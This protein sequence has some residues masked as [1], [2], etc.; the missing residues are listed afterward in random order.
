MEMNKIKL[1]TKI[2]ISFSVV[3]FVIFI[4][5]SLYISLYFMKIQEH[6]IIENIDDMTSKFTKQIDYYMR[7]LTQSARNLAYEPKLIEQ[8]NLINQCDDINDYDRTVFDRNIGDTISRIISL[9]SFSLSPNI[10]Y[11]N[12]Y[13]YSKNMKYKYSFTSTIAGNLDKVLHNKLY[14]DDLEKD[15]FTIY[16]SNSN[17]GWASAPNY[18]VIIPLM[19]NLGNL[20][21]YLEIIQDYHIL[22]EVFNVGS[23]GK[24]I[25]I[26]KYKNIVY[27]KDPLSADTFSFL[28]SGK[29]VSSSNYLRDSNNNYFF[30][31]K[32]IYSQW[33]VFIQYTTESLFAPLNS[34]K[35]A[36]YIFIFVL[37]ILSLIFICLFSKILTTPIIKLRD[38]VLKVN[39]DNMKLNFDGI[40]YNNEIEMLN[41]AF[42]DML[43]RLKESMQSEITAHKEEAKARF[44]ALQAQMSPH[45]IHNVLYLISI[46]IRNDKGEEAVKMCKQLSNMLRYIV[47]SPFSTVT[48]EEE[49]SYMRNYLSLQERCYGESINYT[50]DLQDSVKLITLPRLV[51]QPFVENAIHHGFANCK[52]PWK[53]FISCIENKESWVITISDNGIGINPD[54]LD[55]IRKKISGNK[56]L[57]TQEHPDDTPGMCSMGVANT[58]MRLKLLYGE[59]LNFDI[60][61]CEGSGTTVS[62][63]GPIKAQVSSL[64]L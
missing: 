64:E 57:I 52:P 25:I 49:I 20:C 51:I 39:G 13:I 44:S 26:D 28:T 24:C 40:S 11:T 41:N 27:S 3:M 35:L 42:Q 48:L 38:E 46:C 55:E 56:A 14:K 19:D 53:I 33:N 10:A 9:N 36:N 37:L 34:M 4:S 21:G 22:G 1:Q 6:R 5:F 47:N 62:I 23:L 32:S 16:C 17:T 58:V 2:I 31:F 29:T 8:L 12:I 50:I 7:D 61:S 15:K 43:S 30:H 54:I 18:S 59:E 63:S 45:F 60:S